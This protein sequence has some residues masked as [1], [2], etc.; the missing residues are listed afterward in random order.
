EITAFFV[1]RDKVPGVKVGKKE[2]KMGLRSS[3]TATL[4]L[5]EAV[6]PESNIIGKAGEGFKIFM[7]TLDGGRITIGSM[8]LGL[9]QGALD[10]ALAHVRK[11]GIG[12]LFDE[13]MLQERLANMGAELQA[14]RLLLY[15]AAVRRDAK[16]PYTRFSAM[17]KYFASEAAVR[18]CVSALEILGA[19]G[20]RDHTRVA[21][22]F[23]DIKLCTI[24]E[25]TSQVQQLVIAREML[26]E[27]AGG[28]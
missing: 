10:D 11:L 2:D 3:D 19:E 9:G 8:A 25:G 15:D 6:I 24:G 1:D 12:T 27:E 18:A 7:Q 4:I 26:K 20:M 23:K 21:R 14:G 13:Q 28:A 22:A 16:L 5:E 17:A